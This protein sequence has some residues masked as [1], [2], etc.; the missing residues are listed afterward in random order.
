MQSSQTDE[1]M[2]AEKKFA[3]ILYT[4][5]DIPLDP[6]TRATMLEL[7]QEHAGPVQRLTVCQSCDIKVRTLTPLSCCLNKQHW[8]GLSLLGNFGKY[9]VFTQPQIPHESILKEYF[10]LLTR[11]GPFEYLTHV[12]LWQS[13]EAIMPHREFDQTHKTNLPL[14]VRGILYDQNKGKSFYLWDGPGANTIASVEKENIS[15]EHFKYIDLPDTATYFTWNNHQCLHGSDY[16]GSE[17]VLIAV[18][19]VYSY[20]K[21]Q[22]LMRDS[23]N[24]FKDEVIYSAP[25]GDPGLE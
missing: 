21:Y 24:K 7:W 17:K 11:L 4:P 23:L 22:R 15:K 5:L 9:P 19:G 8:I 6:H 10:D 3:G 2:L 20:A 12:W 16:N 1:R 25:L 18:N 14:I 13:K